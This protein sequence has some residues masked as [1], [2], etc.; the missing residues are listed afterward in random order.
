[1]LTDSIYWIMIFPFLTLR[2]YDLNFVS[3]NFKVFHTYTVILSLLR[4]TY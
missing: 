3:S 2:D 1:M 4:A